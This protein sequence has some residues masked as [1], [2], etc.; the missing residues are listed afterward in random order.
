[1]PTGGKLVGA[2]VFAA[3]AWF[4]TDLVKPLLSEGTQVGMFSPLNAL[5][6]LIMGWTIMGKGAGV[7]Y[8]QALSYGLT[9]VAAITFWALFLWAGRETY[10][11]S[12]RMRYDGPIEALQEMAVYMVEWAGMIAT[13]E[14]L[15]TMIVGG[16]LGG[17]L[18][19]FFARRWS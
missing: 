3:L 18:T 4:V 6:G 13:Q 10:K 17:F 12:I 15:A 2:L 5:I 1:M 7:T 19:E 8:R 9:T 11:N 16:I 14:I